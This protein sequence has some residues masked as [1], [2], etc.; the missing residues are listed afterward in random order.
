MCK[1]GLVICN[2][3]QA[4]ERTFCPLVEDLFPKPLFN[5]TE[6]FTFSFKQCLDINRRADFA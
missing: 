5:L 3:E 1:C 4:V 2:D 6:S